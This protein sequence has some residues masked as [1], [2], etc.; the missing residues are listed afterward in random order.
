M[1]IIKRGLFLILMTLMSWASIF[2]ANGFVVRKIRVEGL[3]RVNENTVL[4]YLPIK[5]GQTLD[6]DQTGQI[7]S[8]L[9]STGFFSEVNLGRQGDTLVITVQERPTIG[10]VKISGNKKIPTKKLQDVLKN[11]GLSEGSIFDNSILQGLKQS[12][13][14][15]YESQGQYNA[16]VTTSVTPES[17]NRVAIDIK[18]DEGKPAHIKSIKIN[19]NHAFS[20]RKLLWQLQETTWRPWTILTHSD[21]YSEDKLTADLKTLSTYYMDRGYARFKVTS[22]DANMSADKKTVNIVINIDE[23][24]IYTMK[25][26]DLTG[27]FPADHDK[28]EKMVAANLKP[29]AKFS[30][31]RILD[32]SDAIKHYY[33][34]QGYAFGAVTPVP[35]YDD[36]NHQVFVTFKIDPGRRVYVRQINFTG[37]NKTQE[38]VLRREMRQEEGG[39][40]NL[41][42]L[43]EGKRRL[44]MLGFLQNV[45]YQ[46]TPVPGH[47]DQVDVN[48]NVNEI[49][50]ATA[51]VQ[52]G[53]SDMY[54]LLY[55]ANI[56]ETNFLGEGKQVS[57]GFQNSEYSNMY[58]LT[59]TNPYYT[60][61]LYTSPSPR[62]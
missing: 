2:A 19:G 46:V 57:L 13:E 6:P 15:Q 5:P 42:G 30:R 12:L 10:S 61:L 43:E 60:C 54:G 4:S 62:D 28:L 41:W 32:I 26:F 35:T 21:Q 48:Y 44:S 55:G 29:G 20:E 51:S 3:Q 56:S 16:T 31:Q 14:Q 24:P 50:S 40:Y 49:S 7:V 17:R 36:V 9:Y 37:N 8:A 38:I 33:G 18:I 22:Y 39:L 59:Y 27:E 53:Y 45:D 11:V 47:P 1:T 52:V 34:D 58:S 23:G 25:G